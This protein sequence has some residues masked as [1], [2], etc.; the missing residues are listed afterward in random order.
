[1]IWIDTSSAKPEHARA[2]SAQLTPMGV[3]HLDA[4]VSGGTKGA[5]AGSLAIMAGG[6]PE[7]F[8]QVKDSTE[9]NGSARSCWPLGAGQLCKLANQAIVAVTISAV[10]EATLAGAKRW[11]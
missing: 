2:Q 11:R 3:A 4:P 9:R 7:V 8:E 10:A 5:E 6:D 1:M